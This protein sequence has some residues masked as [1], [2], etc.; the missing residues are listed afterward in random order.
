ME[1]SISERYMR[2]KVMFWVQSRPDLLK[3]WLNTEPKIL[4]NEQ[5][6]TW[7]ETL[8]KQRKVTV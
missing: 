8:L 6:K 1:I 5:F 3:K 4:E 7:L 2:G